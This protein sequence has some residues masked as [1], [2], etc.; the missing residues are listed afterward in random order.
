MSVLTVEAAT[1]KFLK[2]A[3]IGKNKMEDLVVE[4]ELYLRIGTQQL[5][6]NTMKQSQL[7][8]WALFALSKV[9]NAAPFCC[10]LASIILGKSSF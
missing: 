4:L 1:N 8:V 9:S 3:A 2:I 7:A 6:A 10:L 5:N